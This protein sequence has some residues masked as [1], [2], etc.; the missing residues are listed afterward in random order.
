[1]TKIQ[2]KR[3]AERTAR[4]VPG[5]E[6]S[7]EFLGFANF[8]V[9]FGARSSCLVFWRLLAWS[10]SGFWLHRCNGGRRPKHGKWHNNEWVRY[11]V[12]VRAISL[13]CGFVFA[14]IFWRR[15]TP[16]VPYFFL[17]GPE[18]RNEVCTRKSGSQPQ[19][20]EWELVRNPQP[21]QLVWKVLAVHLQFVP[22]YAPHL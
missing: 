4:K 10:K 9:N 13:F 3:V 18:A 11:V 17:S 8:P 15:S 1:M 14:P 21:V 22:Q 6:M 2:P 20:N 7:M 16:I 12:V 19:S 5:T